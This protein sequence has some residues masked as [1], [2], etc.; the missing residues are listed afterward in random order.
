MISMLQTPVFSRVKVGSVGGE[1]FLRK[2]NEKISSTTAIQFLQ[3]LSKNMKNFKIL[4]FL[5]LFESFY[6]NQE[7]KRL[8][9]NEK[10][11]S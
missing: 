4:D 2:I 3:N 1:T 8:L 6:K 7:R 10:S 11:D 9:K 5:E